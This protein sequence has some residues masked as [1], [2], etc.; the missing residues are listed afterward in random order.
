MH[1]I[2]HIQRWSRVRLRVPAS[3]RDPEAHL[4]TLG[5]NCGRGSEEEA[6]EVKLDFA[7]PWTQISS[8]QLDL[9]GSNDPCVNQFGLKAVLEYRLC[10]WSLT[11]QKP[12]DCTTRS[13]Q[14]TPHAGAA[15]D[16]DEKK[17]MS[18]KRRLAGPVVIGNSIAH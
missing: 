12:R 13:R 18:H 5:V 9:S 4:R 11:R 1:A 17:P 14:L 16:H 2:V 6:G 15:L 7:A 3:R 10:V 8:G